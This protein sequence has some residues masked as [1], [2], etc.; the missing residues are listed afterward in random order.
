M[1]TSSGL[2]LMGKRLFRIGCL[3]IL[4]LITRSVV[5]YLIEPADYSLFFNKIL[6]NKIKENNGHIDMIFLGTSRAHRSF[7]PEV[8]EEE[9]GMDSVFNAS[10]GLQPIEGSYYLLQELVPRCRPDYV[11]M[12]VTAGTFFNQSAALEKIIVLD[13]LHGPVKLEYLLKCFK[14]DE[15][16]N[17]VSRVYRFRNNM[18]LES[19]SEIVHEKQELRENGYSERKA[20][21]D[22]YTDSGFIYSYLTGYVE[23]GPSENYYRFENTVPENMAYL[24]KIIS[25]CEENGIRLFLVTS[26][27]PMMQMYYNK[28][29]QE[30]T[31]RVSAIADEH[32]LPYVNLNYLRGREEWLGDD[33]MFDS[34]HVNG[35]GARRAS[36]KYAQILKALLSGGEMP[37]LLYADLAE[38][39]TEVNR[40]L[41]LH[42]DIAI[43]DMTAKIHITSTQTDNI[44]PLY[45]VQFSED[46]E[47][48]TPVTEWSEQTDLELDLS[49]YRG[50]GHFLIE[51]M[52]PTGEPGTFIKYHV[53]I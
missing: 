10:S 6:E 9:L 20:G 41:A 46:D 36:E 13:R 1:T 21:M 15:Y 3:V 51:A 5:L 40:I 53:P 49:G 11:V 30:F 35:E 34:G 12:D 16:L 19:I 7:D 28:N 45:R 31:D 42:A 24:E 38:L 14:P 22:L 47:A 52:S 17:A 32:G 50:T 23:N 39:K 2:K 26:P 4:L 27:W 29:Y 37:D 43:S 8:F 33:M 48:Y 18:T 44:T 25:L